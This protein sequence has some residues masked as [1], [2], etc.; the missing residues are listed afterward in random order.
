MARNGGTK[1]QLKKLTI[2]FVVLLGLTLSFS[3]WALIPPL[4]E[5]ELKQ[6]A[7]LIVE[8]HVVQI[9]KFEKPFKDRCYKW[10]KY[11]ADFEVRKTLKGQS[12]KII[13]IYYQSFVKDIAYPPCVGG[14]TSYYLSTGSSY[15]L[16]LA[17]SVHGEGSYHFINWSGVM[18]LATKQTLY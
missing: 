14:E 6:E 9:Q 8:G 10:Q 11:V 15:K 3:A 17:D 1:L 18:D 4:S 12:P 5:N 13:K 7:N 16:Y 2:K